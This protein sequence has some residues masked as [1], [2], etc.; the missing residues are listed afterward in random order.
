MVR[1][2][3]PRLAEGLDFPPKE[4]RKEG[5][6]GTKERMNENDTQQSNIIQGWQ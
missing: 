5:T 2:K 6:K 3:A 1:T 4:K